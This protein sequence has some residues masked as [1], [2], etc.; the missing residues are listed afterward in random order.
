MRMKLIS[1]LLSNKK[2]G[3]T[4]VEPVTR[5]SAVYC[6]TTELTTQSIIITKNTYKLLYLILKCKVT[7]AIS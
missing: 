6:S 1:T 4:G 5:R 2:E 7:H 3:C